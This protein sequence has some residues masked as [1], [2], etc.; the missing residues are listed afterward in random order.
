M[1]PRGTLNDS[2]LSDA[3]REPV[4]GTLLGE[5]QEISPGEGSMNSSVGSIEV[6]GLHG[7]LDIALKLFPDVNILYGRNGSGKT[8]LL[9]I[10]A[11][12]LNG[13]LDRFAHLAFTSIVVRTN[14]GQEI[15]IQR[16]SAADE[17]DD[18]IGIFLDGLELLTF[19]VS[20]VRTFDTSL[21]SPTIDSTW[22]N[23]LAKVAD[24][25][26]RER[27]Q[28]IG[29]ELPVGGA[30]YFPAFRTMIEAWW[31]VR[32]SSISSPDYQDTFRFFI[33]SRLTGMDDRTSRITAF[34]RDLFGDFVPAVNYPSVLDIER[35]L[36]QQM[37]TAE[38]TVARG[39]EVILSEAFVNAFSALSPQSATMSETPESILEEIDKLLKQLDSTELVD[40]PD[41][42]RV[43]VYER[44]RRA[45]PKLQTGEQP[46]T[47]ARVLSVYR[48]SLDQQI[49]MQR[50]TF[51][52]IEL[53]V[54]SV[55]EFLD[56]KRIVITRTPSDDDDLRVSIEFLDGAT[57][58]LRTLSSGERQIVSMLYA[59]SNMEDP[60]S[61]VVLIDE[62]ELSLHIDWQRR[63]IRRMEQQLGSRQI[64]VCTHSPEIGGDFES[65][66]QQVQPAVHDPDRSTSIY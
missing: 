41:T 62:P 53:Y 30:A 37:Q 50:E 59:A 60:T 12:V 40:L 34:A 21:S 19:P 28:R 43:D 1:M 48:D 3:F 33:R 52:P 57:E 31:S 15:V 10:L 16:K 2:Q 64:I 25:P 47:A 45:L 29:S 20:M 51:E 65:R 61:R 23:V 13:S 26:I 54:D 18:T 27:L 7:R 36:K 11:N 5:R 8:T 56:D 14:D 4:H 38:L 24:N 9:H 6:R 17:A 46:A 66:Y 58:T 63:L 44:L 49:R 39:S 35:D 32:G 42:R 55:N 22:Q